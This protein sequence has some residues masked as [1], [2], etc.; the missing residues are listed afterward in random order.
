MARIYGFVEDEKLGLNSDLSM[1]EWIGL[2]LE[3]QNKIGALIEQFIEQYVDFTSIKEVSL[4]KDC[5]SLLE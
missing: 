1:F 5:E 2:Y 3:E 4:Q